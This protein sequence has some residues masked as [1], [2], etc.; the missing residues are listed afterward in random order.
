M[1]G[2]IQNQRKY[3]KENED[4]SRVFLSADEKDEYQSKTA[5]R[6]THM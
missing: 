3:I 6:G 4:K 2:Q 1:K 5:Q